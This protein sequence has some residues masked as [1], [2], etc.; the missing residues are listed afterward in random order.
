MLPVKSLT[1]KSK[2]LIILQSIFL[3]GCASDL[4]N[5]SLPD[6]FSYSESHYLEMT[7]TGDQCFDKVSEVSFD[8]ADA[9]K[10]VPDE[11]DSKSDNFS[12]KFNDYIV[13]SIELSSEGQSYREEAKLFNRAHALYGDVIGASGLYAYTQY[14]CQEKPVHKIDDNKMG[15]ILSACTKEL[16]RQVMS[17]FKKGKKPDKKTKTETKKAIRNE[18]VSC[19]ENKLN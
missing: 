8:Y 16:V 7:T 6:L 17:D 3:A 15:D 5:T 14:Y 2:L 13:G 10:N 4:T 12:S 18:L 1:M 19:I 9:M 11:L